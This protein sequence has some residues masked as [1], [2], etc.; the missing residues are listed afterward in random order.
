L[1]IISHSAVSILHTNIVITIKHF[2]GVFFYGISA[3][4]NDYTGR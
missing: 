1:N 3:F 4:F 2:R